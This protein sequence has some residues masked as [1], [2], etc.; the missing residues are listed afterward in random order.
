ML[1]RT[2]AGGMQCIADGQNDLGCIRVKLYTMQFFDGLCR[3]HSA[4]NAELLKY[5][6]SPSKQATI[7]FRI[8]ARVFCL[9]LGLQY[10]HRQI[11]DFCH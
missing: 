11:H 4:V 2:T 1:L 3:G 5:A 10:G 8:S 7:T 9:G 6:K